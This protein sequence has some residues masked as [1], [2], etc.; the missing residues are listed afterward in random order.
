MIMSTRLSGVS[1]AI[2]RP[3]HQAAELSRLVEDE[4]GRPILFP[5][6]DIQP[7]GDWDA[8]DRATDGLH[9]IDGLLFTS[10]NGVTG[11]LDR[12]SSRAIDPS[13]LRGKRVCAVGETT[14]RTLDGRGLR[15]TMMPER[16]TAADLAKALGTEDLK[17]LAF[18]FPT[19]N[20]TSPALAESVRLLGATVDTLV[21]YRTVAPAQDNVD[22][23]YRQVRDGRVGWITFTS[24][25]T[26]NNFAQLFTGARAG[27]IRTMT[28]IAVIGPTT[29]RAAE[30]AGFPPRAVAARSSAKDLV[31]AI[32]AIVA[33]APR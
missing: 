12:L 3:P 31:E 28:R 4:G 23:F 18:L 13:T 19:G 9:M 22:E 27:T 5:T 17:G 21:V 7:P 14:A 11:F 6:I 20:L 25:S 29:G 8:C 26:V 33:P 30:E 24:P 1:V 2:T 15:V 32:C 16:F 10:P